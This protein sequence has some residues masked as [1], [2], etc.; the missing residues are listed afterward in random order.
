MNL[1]GSSTNEMFRSLNVFLV[2]GA[3][4]LLLGCGDGRPSRVKV[5]GQVLIDGE[6]LGHGHIRFLPAGGRVGVGKLN[7]EGRFAMSTYGKYD[8]VLTG[9]HR[10]EIDGSEEISAQQKKWHAPKKYFGFRTSGLTQEITEAT[11]SLVINLTWDGK[12]PFVERMR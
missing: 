10:V 12:E 11:D 5:S 2:L 6:P 4:L 8:G 1:A 9:T 7:E 3:T